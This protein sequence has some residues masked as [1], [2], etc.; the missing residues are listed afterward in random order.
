MSCHSLSSPGVQLSTGTEWPRPHPR[1]HQPGDQD[2]KCSPLWE[3]ETWRCPEW[4]LLS[5]EF[6]LAQYHQW[7]DR[8]HHHLPLQGVW[9]VGGLEPGTD[10]KMVADNCLVGARLRQSEVSSA[11]ER[12]QTRRTLPISSLRSA[13]WTFPLA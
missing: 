5:E 3:T 1:W 11:R 13:R 10:S 6:T 4:V 12:T 8:P 9:Q 2:P 7:R